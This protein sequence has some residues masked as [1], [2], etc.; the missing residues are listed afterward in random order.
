MKTIYLIILLASGEVKTSIPMDSEWDCITTA[1]DWEQSLET[2]EDQ[3]FCVVDD[4][5]AV[6]GTKLEVYPQ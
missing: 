6:I 4:R 3:A 5:E 1:A 2:R